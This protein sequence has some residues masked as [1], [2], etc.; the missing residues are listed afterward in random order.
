MQDS[1]PVAGRSESGPAAP[2]VFAHSITCAGRPGPGL[3]A[4]TPL[5]GPGGTSIRGA[6]LPFLHLGRELWAKGLH[7]PGR[8]VS[9]ETDSPPDF[10]GEMATD[11]GAK[12]RQ[13][14]DGHV[15]GQLP[16]GRV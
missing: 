15:V 8:R 7:N 10:P 11:S 9:L 14:H 12:T 5:D 3:H 6:A 13:V 4:S 16:E 1:R 2:L